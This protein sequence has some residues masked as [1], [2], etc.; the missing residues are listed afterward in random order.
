MSK[1]RR[2]SK[3]TRPVSPRQGARK[4]TRQKL[5]EETGLDVPL[6]PRR[7]RN[8]GQRGPIKGQGGRPSGPPKVKLSPMVLASTAHWLRAKYP[9]AKTLHAAAS[10]AL[11]DLSGSNDQ[12][13]PREP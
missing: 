4:N 6:H 11:D 3:N 5:L 12:A 9:Q 10:Q 1:P 7:P 2:Q 13:V 8:A